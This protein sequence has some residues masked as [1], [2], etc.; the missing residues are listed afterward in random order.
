MR[1][2]VKDENTNLRLLLPTGLF[3]NRVT[4]VLAPGLLKKQ[5]VTIERK[6]AV[7]FVK[8][9]NRYRRSH[10]DWVLVEVH[11]KDGA[12]VKIKL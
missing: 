8:A 3:L 7:A 6:Q 5:G 2:R 9:L 4:A 12:H 10:K 1:I 11:S